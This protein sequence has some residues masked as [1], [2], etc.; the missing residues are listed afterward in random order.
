MARRKNRI[1]FE[2]SDPS[3]ERRELLAHVGLAPGP[4]QTGPIHPLDAVTPGRQNKVFINTL[5]IRLANSGQ[6]T[7][8]I[9]QAFQAFGY[10]FLNRPIHLTGNSG[11]FSDGQ[12]NEPPPGQSGS[13][14]IQAGPIL[15]RRLPVGNL[16]MSPTLANG[17]AQLEQQTSLAL[18]TL[19]FSSNRIQ[20]SVRAAP[21]F[22]PLA[23][24]ALI[25]FAQQQI[26]ELGAVLEAHP[27]V[28]APDGTLVDPA[29]LVALETAYN[30]I[31]NA[32]AENSMHPT[33]FQSPSDFFINP[34]VHFTLDFN[35]IP[36]RKGPGFFNRG[37]G[38]VLLSGSGSGHHR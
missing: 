25:P 7:N 34:K 6:Q 1:R 33:L 17:L 21:K 5:S 37:P 29:P 28:L 24:Q 26:A 36:A 2:S 35:G 4:A 3:L 20:P 27:P 13:G 8:R 23:Q 12:G 9:N 38:G 11:T 19:Q 18:S 31:L 30:N 32:V 15:N 22:T 10:N 14:Q 16:P